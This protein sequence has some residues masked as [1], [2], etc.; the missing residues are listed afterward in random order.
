MLGKEKWEEIIVATPR[1]SLFKGNEYEWQGLLNAGDSNNKQ[2][3]DHV[4][5]VLERETIKIRRGDKKDTTPKENNAEINYDYKQPISY[6]IVT[7]KDENGGLYVFVYERLKGGTETRLH[8]Q[9]SIGVGGHM[10]VLPEDRSFIEVV[11]EEAE[12]ELE[13]ELIFEGEGANVSEYPVNIVGFI[14]DE[15]NDVGKVHLGVLH[16]LGVN[17]EHQVKVKEVEQLKGEWMSL[18]QIEEVKDRLESWSKI[19]LEAIKSNG[20][21][22]VVHNSL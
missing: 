9:L 11:R 20:K 19:A 10:N 7:K 21:V 4:I 22:N 5:N 17:W 2:V 14:N 1:E 16:T 6:S 15:S 8:N 13:E 12:R 18:E 3:I